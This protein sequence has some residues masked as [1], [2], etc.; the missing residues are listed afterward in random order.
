MDNVTF[1]SQPNIEK[2]HFIGVGTQT[3]CTAL[4][5][6]TSTIVIHAVGI[7]RVLQDI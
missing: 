7:E 6:I 5:V 1:K 2:V 4:W 3:E